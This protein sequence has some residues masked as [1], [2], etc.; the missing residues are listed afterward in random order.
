M[1]KTPFPLLAYEHELRPPPKRV[2]TMPL[3]ANRSRLLT[4]LIATLAAALDPEQYG[5]RLAEL[6]MQEALDA[7]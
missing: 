4:K 7:R 6:E 3:G 2:V 5:P 1:K